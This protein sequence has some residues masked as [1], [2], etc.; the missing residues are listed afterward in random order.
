M[1]IFVGAPARTK[2]QYDSEN[3]LH[4]I[5]SFNPPKMTEEERAP[6]DISVALDRSGSMGT[7]KME[8][9][10]QSLL[11]LVEH[12]RDGDTLAVVTF[13]SVVEVIFDLMEMTSDNKTKAQEAINQIVSRG[14]TNLSGGLFKALDYLRAKGSEE[15]RVRKCLMFTDGHAN[16]G[17]SDPGKLTEATL[18]YRAGVGISSFGYGNDHNAKL[19]DDISQ[20]GNFYFI[21]SPDKILHAFGTELGGLISTWGQN[22][23]V[24]LKAGDGVEIMEVLNDLTVEEKDGTV[25]VQCDDLLSDHPYHLALKLKT[26]ERKNLL[27][28][29]TTLVSAVAKLV[30]LA[31]KKPEEHTAA[32]KATFVKAE[33]ADKEDDKDVMKHVAVH[34]TARAIVNASS[35]AD[36][37]DFKGAQNVML[38]NARLCCS[39]SPE[40]E[41][42]SN[43]LID[44]AY[45]CETQ[46]RRTGEKISASARKSFTRQRAGAGGQ[47]AGGINIDDVM[48]SEMQCNVA[49]S[50]TASADGSPS[51]VVQP[52]AGSV[53]VIRQPGDPAQKLG[54]VKCG[55][56]GRVAKDPSE[57]CEHLAARPQSLSK[58]RSSRW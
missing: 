32:I 54:T 52:P 3:E 24:T 38:M 47:S 28:R 39:A 15:G 7:D 2:I 10:K 8:A 25:V 53:P 31:E 40:M 50:F 9:A 29:E 45:A 14:M 17:L 51:V 58:R 42:I 49:S 46:Y 22:V 35:L 16:Q 33:D 18:E 19:L 4:A 44:Q 5:F 34:L 23:E 1:S 41:A 6:L 13:D 56:C 21:D 36:A 20:D 55:Q 30:N 27:P 48:G 43:G 26:E 57:Y 12:L 11:K 37:G